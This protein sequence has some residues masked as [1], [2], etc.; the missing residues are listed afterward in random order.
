M[1]EKSY[2]AR[3]FVKLYKTPNFSSEV[4]FTLEDG[5]FVSYVNS[6]EADITGKITIRDDIADSW[7]FVEGKNDKKGWCPRVYLKEPESLNDNS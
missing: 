6:G 3:G 4:I 2:S 7:F 1:N 5:D